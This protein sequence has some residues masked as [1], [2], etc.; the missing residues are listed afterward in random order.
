ME[1]RPYN[2]EKQIFDITLL[3]EQ[4]NNYEL[5]QDK[6]YTI[7]FSSDCINVE[8][9]IVATFTPIN[10]NYKGQ[11]FTKT[12]SINKAVIDSF[13]LTVNKSVYSSTPH[14][15]TATV[16]AGEF[17]I[18]DTETYN[19]YQLIYRREGSAVTNLTSVGDIEVELVLLDTT[20]YELKQ[21]LVTR[22]TYTI[23]KAEISS[24]TLTDT[25]AEFNN[26]N[27]KN[28]NQNKQAKDR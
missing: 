9:D 26:Q 18:Y 5:K 8:K 22:L 25:G 15:I 10:G 11:A 3:D 6:D 1:D 19:E 14:N 4:A 24:I 21:G 12:F 27:H 20:N 7:T 2:R 16:K 23:T 17:E 13:Q 28:K